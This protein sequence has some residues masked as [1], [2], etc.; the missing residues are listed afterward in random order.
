MRGSDSTRNLRD[1]PQRS[2]LE[3]ADIPDLLK[4]I[5]N[6]VRTLFALGSYL[7]AQPRFERPCLLLDEPKN[8]AQDFF[9]WLTILHH[10]FK[11]IQTKRMM[12]G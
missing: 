1:A 4:E 10:H 6:S 12:L 7:G 3:N 2:V 5:L 9:F 8:L 11:P